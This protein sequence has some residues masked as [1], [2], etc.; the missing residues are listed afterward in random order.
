MRRQVARA[1][2]RVTNHLTRPVAARLP[3]LGV[4]VHTGRRTG[5]RYRTPVLV[6]AAPDG[7]TVALVYGKESEWVRNVLAAGEC[8]L[9]TRGRVE[10]LTVAGVVH[11]ERRGLVPRPVAAALG[12][13]RVADFLVLTRSTV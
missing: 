6:F 2:R 13:L 4:I 10:H 8:A 5:R 7:Y 11:D 3:G 12:V 1:N 9:E